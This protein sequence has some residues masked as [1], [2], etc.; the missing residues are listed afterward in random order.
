MTRRLLVIL[1]L[2]AGTVLIERQLRPVD[3]VD[4]LPL[5]QLPLHLGAWNGREAK[6]FDADVVSALGVDDYVNR[7][8]V[9]QGT[10]AASVYVGYYRAQRQGASIHSPLNC[11]PGSGWEPLD[12]ERVA[13]A[14]GA[15]RRVTIRKGPL[16]LLVLYWYQTASR[17]EGDEY[18]SRVFTLLDTLRHGRNDAALVRVIVPAGTDEISDARALA[19]A[20]DLAGRIEREVGRVLFAGG[21]TGQT[22]AS[23]KPL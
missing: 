6:P 15:A 4:A 13:F 7:T 14:G 12:A 23:R 20:A 11:L 9:A 1:V 19:E 5:A 21:A 16:R 2:L 17:I 18:R 22:T 10:R 3:R 8:Y